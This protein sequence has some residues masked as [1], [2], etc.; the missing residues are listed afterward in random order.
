MFHQDLLSLRTCYT[1]SMSFIYDYRGD[2]IENRYG[3]SVAV[4]N[5]DGKLLAYAGDPKLQV[6][7]RSSAKPFQVQALFLSGAITRFGITEKEIALAIGSHEGAPQHVEAV[8]GF[9]KKLGLDVSDLACGAHMPGD[10]ESRKALEAAGQKPTALHNNCSGKHSGMLSVALSLG[11][12]LHNYERLEHPVQQLNLQTIK[13][14]SGVTNIPWA[15]DGCSVPTFVL[16]LENAARMFALLASP[17]SAPVKYQESLEAAFQAM[18][19]YP[20]MVA[21][22]GEIDTVIMQNIS[23][24]VAKR[25]GEGYYG[26]A[27]RD[28]AYGPLGV[29]LKAEVG[30]SSSREPAVVKVLELLEQD[31]TALEKWREPILSNHRKIKTGYTKADIELIWT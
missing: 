14:L 2:T 24:A 11:A 8:Q 25:G 28:T 10:Y 23:G 31:I 29:V 20:E 7:M 12:P 4:V 18:Q 26:L 15:I 21:G 1:E 6:H 17:A 27:L 30:K 3:V 22:V 16:P 19:Q 5:P 9:L 13:D